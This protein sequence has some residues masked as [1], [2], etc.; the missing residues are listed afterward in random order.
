[1]IRGAIREEKWNVPSELAEVRPTAEKL[2]KFLAPLPL[3]ESER[4]DIRLCFE[5]SLINAVKYGNR[6]KREIPVL[7][8]IAYNDKEIFI[9]V[10]DRGKGFDPACV[11]D[12]TQGENLGAFG[13]RGIYLIKHLMDEVAYKG[14]GN[15]LEMTKFYKKTPD[16]RGKTAWK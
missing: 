13:G 11:R 6:E 2:L 1:M 4:F 16:K 9:A 5:E 12:P 7:V 15:R 3:S 8:E 14:C 10:E